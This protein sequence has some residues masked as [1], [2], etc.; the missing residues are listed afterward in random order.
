VIERRF[1]LA[2][3][4]GDQQSE[5]EFLASF[6]QRNTDASAIGFVHHLWPKRS[7]YFPSS[8]EGGADL[9]IL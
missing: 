4:T 2:P 3:V 9:A 6:S 7:R 1:V 5:K 8:L